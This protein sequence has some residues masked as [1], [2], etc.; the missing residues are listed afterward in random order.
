MTFSQRMGITPVRTALQGRS[1][2]E[3]T[4]N[5]LW[6]AVAE[7]IPKAVGWPLPQTWMQGLYNHIWADHFKLPVDDCPPYEHNIRARLR[8][9][10]QEGEWYE[11]YDLLEFVISS[12][13]NTNADGLRKAVAL[14][15][16]EERAGFQ[17]VTGQFTEITDETEIAA[18]EQAFQATATDRFEPA[19]T[20]LSAALR[21][22]SDRQAPDLRN[23]I[24]ESISA[25]EAV[26]QI[27]S[28]DRQAELGR[29]IRAIEA[30]TP[31]HGALR[32]ALLSLYGYTSDADGIRHAL[33][34]APNVDAADAKF[35]LV[36]CSAFVVYLIQKTSPT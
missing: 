24:K 3:S 33:S 18:I 34:E 6:S 31:L 10:F 19:R 11:V 22:L 17:L 27:I 35:M 29:A 36:V 30:R 25:V 15:L 28:G 2:D 4:R 16:K 7:S 32:A 20:H 21:H 9:V 14:I 23:S 26:T 1:L 8:R 13:R 5:R 12:P